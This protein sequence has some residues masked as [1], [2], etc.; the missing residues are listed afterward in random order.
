MFG[1]HMKHIRNQFDILQNVNIPDWHKE[2]L[3]LK[4][5]GTAPQ[6][7]PVQSPGAK[8]KKAKKQ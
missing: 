7:Q 3:R 6:S 4:G 1:E 2:W 8:G 5:S